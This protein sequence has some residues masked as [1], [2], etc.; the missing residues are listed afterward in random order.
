MTA[1]PELHVASIVDELRDAH[2]KMLRD[3]IKVSPAY[4]VRASSIGN[5]CAREL[6]YEQTAFEQRAL[7]EPGLQAIFDLGNELEGYVVRM[8]NDM[9]FVVEQRNRAVL[10][11]QHNISGHLDGRLRRRNGEGS[12]PIEIK[13]LNPYT[14]DSITTLDDIRGSRQAW[15]RKYYAQLQL[16]QYLESDELGLFV[17]LNKSTGWP[18]FIGSPYD[19]T[20]VDQ[21]LGRADVVK[22]SVLKGEPPERK[23]S[24]DCRRCPFVHVCLPDIDFGPGAQVVDEPELIEAI[25]RREE[26]RPG[27]QAFDQADRM[28]KALLEP[29]TKHVKE[30]KQER[31][32]LV[33]P[34]SLT[35]A[36][37]ERKGHVVKPFSFVQW[38]VEQMTPAAAP[39]PTSTPSLE[40]Q[41]LDTVKQANNAVNR[42]GEGE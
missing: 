39:A 31:Q 10:D 7:Y 32:L 4:S 33:G 6:Y 23:R 1:A 35:G 3:K 12:W 22:E 20:F 40:Q 34:Y 9:G 29:Q 24:L 5:E 42:E 16:Y 38:D 2:T 28:V 36:L 14:A 26:N 19:K 15:V 13:G 27:K 8:L 37:Q 18:E 25:R 30:S 21:L 17:L 41:L 11:R